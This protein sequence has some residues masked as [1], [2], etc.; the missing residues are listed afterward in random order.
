MTPKEQIAL[1]EAALHYKHFCEALGIDLTKEDTKDTPVRVAKLFMEEFLKGKGEMPFSFTTFPAPKSKRPQLITVCGNRFVSV[2]AHHHLPVIGYCH[3]CYIP[4]ETI[5]GLSKIP[6]LIEWRAARPTVQ[7]ELTNDIL[8]E[9]VVRLKPD[10][11]GI[12]LV[13]AHECMSCRGV[14]SY[15]SRTHT[16]AF[17]CKDDNYD[18]FDTTKAEFQ[19]NI[20]EWYS[21]KGII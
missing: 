19:H 15:E 4:G 7:E 11:V 8:N 10:Y 16:N 1:D 17:W 5:V 6:R 12:K 3:V 14:R 20:E 18:D 21:G 9:L 2:C 13:A